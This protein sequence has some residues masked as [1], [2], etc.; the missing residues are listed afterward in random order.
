MQVKYWLGGLLMFSY[1][2]CAEAEF[3]LSLKPLEDSPGYVFMV[4]EVV[5]KNAHYADLRDVR[6]I[7][8]LGDEVPMRLSK[9]ADQVKRTFSETTLPVFSLNQSKLVPVSSK[10]VKTTWDGDLQSYTVNTSNI[11][12]NYLLNQETERLDTIL[13]DASSVLDE[14][15]VALNVDWQFPNA[16]NRVFYIELMGSNDLSHW[17]IIRSKHKMIELDT[18]DRVVIENGIPL[19]GTSF[20]FYQLRFLNQ[21]IPEVVAVKASMQYQAVNAE[22]IWSDVADFQVLDAQEHGHTIEWKL[23]GHFPVEA[24]KFRFDY[25][26]LMADVQVFSKYSEQASWRAVTKGSIYEVGAGEMSIFNNQLTLFSNNHRYWK[27]TS[28]S[29]ISSQ[30][31][32]SIS[33][34]W[35]QHQIQFLAQGE[36][37]YSLQFG[38][39]QRNQRPDNLWYNKF[40]QP[41]KQSMFS[42]TVGLG[43]VLQLVPENTNIEHD[44]EL[45]LNYSQWIFWG[46]LIIVLL[47]LLNMASKLLKEVSNEGTDL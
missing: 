27:M 8:A 18:G 40:S 33:F 46:L 21:P 47:V 32:D 13:I 20:E 41:L 16:G 2:L 36:G 31:V 28:Q 39:Q 19:H 22:L 15:A 25:K 26:N 12:K 1:M 6:V 14:Y 23:A 42:N 5:Y 44:A 45:D 7:N 4:P 3:S 17:Q 11:V 9:K 35:R 37:P 30:W 34:A 29:A 38:D 10:Q 43:S 24:V